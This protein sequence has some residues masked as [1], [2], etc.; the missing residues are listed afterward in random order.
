M[1]NRAAPFRSILVPL[2]G[3]DLAAEA[4]P[5]A[6]AIARQGGGQLRLALV[7][8]HPAIPLDAV[9][10]K[11]LT[12]LDLATHKAE[13]AYLRGVRSGLREDGVRVASAV[14]LT[15]TVGPSLVSYVRDLGI[16]LVVM[17]THGRGGFRRLWLGSTADH[18]VRQLDIP[19]L[20]VRPAPGH[21]AESPVTRAAKVLVPL[22]GSPLAEE[23][24]GPAW[25]LARTWN[26]DLHLVRVVGPVVSA[27]P[28]YP[29][30]IVYDEELTTM[31]RASAQ[32]YLDRVIHRLGE[33]GVR[34]T[35][36][37]II[38]RNTADTIL[39]AAQAARV[40]ALAIATHGRGGLGRAVLGSVADKLVRG[41]EVPVLVWRP[42]GRLT[43][44]PR[45]AGASQARHPR[46]VRALT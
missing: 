35:G 13:R 9:N 30:S 36:A 14:T 33:E 7:H 21:A 46:R 32:A 23:A 26:A 40:G 1:T 42:T 18:L 43:G 39:E 11:T 5:L 29:V 8:E 6:A 3:S 20:L 31:A 24:L 12:S 28:L 19:V 15:G 27:D 45:A 25:E 16:E 44:K 37:A 38:G 17:A 34:A 22:D 41:A 4:L 10:A 2:D